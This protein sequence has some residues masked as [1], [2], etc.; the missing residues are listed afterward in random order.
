[1][2]KISTDEAHELLIE[3]LSLDNHDSSAF[4]AIQSKLWDLLQR[5]Q[6]EGLLPEFAPIFI[7]F[8]LHLGAR[9]SLQLSLTSWIAWLTKARDATKII[10]NIAPLEQQA[11]FSMLGE[12][13]TAVHQYQEALDAYLRALDSIETSQLELDIPHAVVYHNTALTLVHLG[14]FQ[15]ALE[16]FDRAIAIAEAR[17]Y[18]QEAAAF[19]VNRA[20][21]YHALGNVVAARH[22]L[23]I[24]SRNNQH[25]DP[26]IELD[27]LLVLGNIE[28]ASGDFSRAV[29]VYE[30]VLEK[31]L[32]IKDS[33]A[34]ANAHAN[35]AI[36]YVRLGQ[37]GSAQSHF[38]EAILGF[39]SL[40][41]TN[42]IHQ[43]NSLMAAFGISENPELELLRAISRFR[44]SGQADGLCRSLL[45]LGLLY[46]NNHKY[47][48]AQQCFQEA[49]DLSSRYALLRE[50]VQALN[51]L[52][53]IYDRFGDYDKGLVVGRKIL[54]L[55]HHLGNQEEVGEVFLNVGIL[56]A[57]KALGE[58]AGYQEAIDLLKR[59]VELLRNTAKQGNY[60]KAHLFLS[61][62]Y[63]A[64]LWFIQAEAHAIQAV[65]VFNSINDPSY[66]IMGYLTLGSIYFG[67]QKLE[68]LLDI[69]EKGIALTSS[70]SDHDAHLRFWQMRCLAG[71]F[72]YSHEKALQICQ[73][74]LTACRGL[75]KD[76]IFKEIEEMYNDLVNKRV[77]DKPPS[78]PGGSSQQTKS[79][80]SVNV[81]GI[82]MQ[83][84]EDL[85][86]EEQRLFVLDHSELLSPD[87]DNSLKELHHYYAS[88][89][90]HER[91]DRVVALRGRLHLAR[92]FGIDLAFTSKRFDEGHPLHGIVGELLGNTSISPIQRQR[93]AEKGLSY[94]T[95]HDNRIL[96]HLLKSTY[97]I[98]R[99]EDTSGNYSENIE[100][101]LNTFIEVKNALT[102][103]DSDS[104]KIEAFSNLGM[105][106]GMRQKGVYSENLE[107]SRNFIKEALR[108]AKQ[109]GNPEMIAALQA[110]LAT[111]YAQRILGDPQ[112][113]QERAIHLYEEV[114]HV[115][116]PGRMTREY[117]Q[118][119]M[120]LGTVFK[121]RRRGDPTQNR[122][123]A[124]QHYLNGLQVAQQEP[125][126]QIVSA[127]LLHE[128]ATTLI[129]DGKDSEIEQ[130]VNY[131]IEAVKLFPDP[132]HSGWAKTNIS[133]AMAW[134]QYTSGNRE[135]H[136]RKALKIL[137]QVRANISQ[138]SAPQEWARCF[139]MMGV[140]YSHLQ[141]GV[142]STHRRNALR[143]FKTAK[144]AL[145]LVS[146]P[147]RF[148]ETSRKIANIYLELED[149]ESVHM[150]LKQVFEA[151][152]LIYTSTV[153]HDSQ[154][155]TL[156]E[157][158]ALRSLDAWSLVQLGALEEAVETLERGRSRVL[159][160]A[161][162][163]HRLPL[164]N[165]S[166]P[167]RE[168]IE[169]L[170][171]KVQLLESTA[172]EFPNEIPANVF[173]SVSEELGEA[174]RSLTQAIEAARV[175]H[176]E[177]LPV[178]LSFKNILKIVQRLGQPVVY[179][180]TTEF[181]SLM[182][183]VHPN[184]PRPDLII[185]R[186]VTLADVKQLLV[187]ENYFITM[188]VG[189]LSKTN[190]ILEKVW[191]LFQTPVDRLTAHLRSRGYRDSFWTLCG[192]LSTLPLSAM[193][194][195][196]VSCALIPS[197]QVLS[198]IQKEAYQ[199]VALAQK[200]LGVADP[201]SL[202]NTQE[203]FN[204]PSLPLARSELEVIE[205][206]C[207]PAYERQ[208]LYNSDA[209]IDAL[210]SPLLSA[211]IV[212]FACHGF[213]NI[214]R[215]LSS[216][217]VLANR[218]R[219]TLND[220]LRQKVTFPS[221][222]LVLLSACQTGVVAIDKVPDEVI[223]IPAGLMQTGTPAVISTLWPVSDLATALLLIRFYQVFL[224]NNHPARAL[225]AAQRW[226]RSVSLGKIR[227]LLET[228]ED[229]GVDAA[230]EL[231]FR[232][233][234]GDDQ[235]V[236]FNSPYFWAAFTFSGIYEK[237]NS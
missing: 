66:E 220:L 86:L 178:G 98:A 149:W 183:V 175:N 201:S 35:L 180:A 144:E 55:A 78:Y 232:L 73:S 100:A 120:M 224:R 112:E 234:S 37:E 6:P 192:L 231:R 42:D 235:V 92:K 228:L 222:R 95:K 237:D 5:Q 152:D 16:M 28:S 170:R 77:S 166:P 217:L 187:T 195:H 173:V 153:T 134:M 10:A 84:L 9:A 25:R 81:P 202:P 48:K 211:S 118:A 142:V 116:Q 121:R 131:L 29:S 60:G 221:A 236:P 52:I 162:N 46:A 39:Q 209:T 119:Q 45:N 203:Q 1:M 177:L 18:L 26:I 113:N 125:T 163:L 107:S 129:N 230:S 141:K 216:M 4:I 69:S 148:M 65:K 8:C 136:Y 115:L 213:F 204:F 160:E 182:L 20:S 19:L 38:H 109:N 123:A 164:E 135:D 23:G 85:T 27:L 233:P 159:G 219:L 13:Y 196:Q 61:Q 176:G 130:A 31:A 14:R 58:Q 70:L 89:L 83:L 7:Q 90:D 132:K 59:G 186:D 12:A 17:N 165:L 227:H 80:P 111:T 229:E 139:Y 76:P 99:I 43:L 207:A 11:L 22:D 108:V 57:K 199:R 101:A 171:N 82:L 127:M 3:M 33:S 102:D 67:Q 137:D 72:I 179:M 174:R 41:R 126:L 62:I 151:H 103:S 145:P 156:Q 74:A 68:P 198:A 150:A 94:V 218:D 91:L 63:L 210:S 138:R 184:S 51:N 97:G 87:V 169:R 44:E 143:C 75:E 133:L 157:L 24:A 53:S 105:V 79:S 208:I 189:N 88:R 50:Q 147:W 34:I 206:L 154:V 56:H 30:Q 110:N 64:Q 47:Q 168:E 40:G 223:G 190:A 167:R 2:S 71:Y 212:H 15:D 21:T 188:T 215:P 225:R 191:S 36:N 32:S 200:L 214:N 104:L 158:G 226:L 124:I 114:L 93:L 117:V 54:D 194:S 128:L 140:C 172:R 49:F 155:E 193:A 96:W 205:Y 181:G 106:Y 161:L 185:H 122:T 146:D 197:I